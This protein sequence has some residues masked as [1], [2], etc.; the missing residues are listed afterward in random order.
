MSKTITWMDDI[1]IG[2]DFGEGNDSWRGFYI[3]IRNTGGRK[4]LNKQGQ[5]QE[6]ASKGD[7]WWPSREEATNFVLSLDS[8]NSVDRDIIETI[9]STFMGIANLTDEENVISICQEALIEMEKVFPTQ[10]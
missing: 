4:Y 5:I 2:S 6:G 9:K 1:K 8:S 10:K 7:C 3:V